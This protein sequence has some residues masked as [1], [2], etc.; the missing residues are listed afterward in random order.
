VTEIRVPKNKGYIQWRRSEGDADA[1][2]RRQLSHLRLAF[3]LALADEVINRNDYPIFKL[4][5]DSKPRK[6]FLEIEEYKTLRDAMPEHL[7]DTVAFPYYTGCRTGAAA[8]ITW[9]MVSRTVP[10]LNHGY[11]RYNIKNTDDV[12]EAYQGWTV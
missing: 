7:R 11:E 12:K 3:N 1:I 2:I 4:P 9:E 10:R 8:E 6:G 5:K